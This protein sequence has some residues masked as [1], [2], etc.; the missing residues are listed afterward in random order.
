MFLKIYGNRLMW[1]SISSRCSSVK[2]CKARADKCFVNPVVE[3]RREE[4]LQ[5][6]EVVMVTLIGPPGG[7]PISCV[8]LDISGSGI[9][10]C[11]PWPIPAGVPLQIK[12]SNRAVI[13][14]AVRCEAQCNED[15]KVGIMVH[16]VLHQKLD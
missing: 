2:G 14:E 1:P 4:R 8:V 7:P 10:V 13:G 12:S 6:N 9:S 15:Y 5:L 11:S 16:S 3:R